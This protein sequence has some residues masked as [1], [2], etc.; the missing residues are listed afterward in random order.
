M[1][2]LSKKPVVPAWL[3][4]RVRQRLSELVRQASAKLGKPI[5]PPTVSFDLRGRTAGQAFLAKNHIR[6]NAVLLAE[7]IVDFME[8]TIPH[9]L[10]HL[11]THRVYGRRASAHG[12][13]WQHMMRDVFNVAPS[14]CHRLD[15]TRASVSKAEWMYHCGCPGKVHELTARRHNTI[16]RGGAYLC[17]LCGSRLVFSARKNVA[18]EMRNAPTTAQ[19]AYAGLLAQKAGVELPDDVRR[20]RAA[21]KAF[22][23]Q[24]IAAEKRVPP[25]TASKRPA[26][27]GPP[28]EKQLA[29][30]QSLAAR[31]GE[32]VPEEALHSKRK[33]SEWLAARA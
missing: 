30:A 12:P 9:E 14:R 25:T 4:S 27:D 17:K 28:T 5:P 22:I 3:E 8:D 15:T 19:V 23:D 33:M 16:Q 32:V 1:A 24:H 7:N 29:F 6:L 20:D 13:E 2:D 21:C 26:S 31:M 11:L 10:A 18:A